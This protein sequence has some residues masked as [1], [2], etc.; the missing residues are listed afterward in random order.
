MRI[1]LSRTSTSVGP[2]DTCDCE[3]ISLY[4]EYPAAKASKTS[5]AFTIFEIS[6]FKY[7]EISFSSLA[8]VDATR[9]IILSRTDFESSINLL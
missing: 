1:S 6:E 3:R 7:I 8:P 9:S 4:F 5:F 2:L